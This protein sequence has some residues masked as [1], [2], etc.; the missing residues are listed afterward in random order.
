L[1]FGTAAELGSRTLLKTPTMKS[2]MLRVNLFMG[3]QLPPAD[4]DGESDPYCVFRLGKLKLK[5]EV[6]KNTLNP[7]WYTSL[8]GQ[9]ELPEDLN[10]APALHCLG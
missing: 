10:L 6:Q 9:V 1:E 4:T 7:V 3:R 5:T 8:E 2:Y